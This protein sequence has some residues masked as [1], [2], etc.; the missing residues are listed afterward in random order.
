VLEVL[1]GI[2]YLAQSPLV[3]VVEAEQML[4]Q[5]PLV[6]PAVVQ[7]KVKV[8]VVEIHRLLLQVKEIMAGL[9]P[10]LLVVVE[11]GQQPLERQQHPTTVVL[12]VMAQHHQSLVHR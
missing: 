11:E 8:L 2:L 4:Q 5:E 3:V 1:E 9:V 7:E 10:V 6:V 12:A